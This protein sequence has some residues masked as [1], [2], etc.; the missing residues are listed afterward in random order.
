MKFTQPVLLQRFLDEFE[1]PTGNYTTPAV[2]GQVLQPCDENNK[3]NEKNQKIYRSGVGKLL[4]L[5]KWSRPDILNAVREL[6]RFMMAAN[7]NH[8]KAMYRVMKY[9]VD[10]P[11][12]GWFLKPKGVWDG[13]KNFKFIISGESDSDFAKDPQKRRSVSGWATFLNDAPVTIKSKMQEIATLCVTEA[14]LVAAVQC[15]QDMIFTMRVLELIGLQVEKPMVLCLDNQGAIDL[16]NNWST[17]GQTR[18]IDVRNHFMCDIKLEGTLVVEH[19][20]SEKNC[21]DPF[22]KNMQGP[23]FEKH[24]ATFVSG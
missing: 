23:A 22:T 3:L 5:M 10:T 14:E 18:H 24:M 11:E 17:G 9:C 6:L 2:P 16:I 20:Q 13:T 4:H 7:P 8:L 15:A 12:R 19:V 21:V 1:L